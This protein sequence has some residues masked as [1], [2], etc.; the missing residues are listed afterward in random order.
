M[1]WGRLGVGLGWVRVRFRARF[2]V[3]FRGRG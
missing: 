1:E 3:R 2:R